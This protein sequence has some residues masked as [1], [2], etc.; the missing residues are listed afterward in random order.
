MTAPTEAA[1]AAQEAKVA[2]ARAFERRIGRQ[3]VGATYI[4]VGLLVIGV[5]LMIA[6][7]ISPLDDAP[8]FAPGAI[9][10]DILTLQPTGFLWLGLAFVI[11]TP[12]SRVIVALVSYLHAGDRLMV[13]VSVGILVVITVG[14]V[15]AIAGRG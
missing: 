2:S 15:A 5:V 13:V 4:A 6:N 8:T 9:V 11:A 14:V 10:H 1:Q 12:I 3:L 7:G